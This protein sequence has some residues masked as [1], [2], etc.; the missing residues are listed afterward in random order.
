MSNAPADDSIDRAHVERQW[1]VLLERA[2][3]LLEHFRDLR[4][5]L[6]AAEVARRTGYRRG[7]AL[8]RALRER[9]LPSFWS[10]RNGLY[11]VALVEAHEGGRVLG[12]WARERGDYESVYYSFVKKATGRPWSE[13]VSLGSL[14]LKHRYL[15]EWAAFLESPS[16]TVSSALGRAQNAE[17]TGSCHTK[18][19]MS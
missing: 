8:E 1:C 10:L 11:V 4:L 3:F 19:R 6:T 14:R 5:G 2:S 7:D 17:S 16:A 12:R 15:G 18:I 13:V 9:Q